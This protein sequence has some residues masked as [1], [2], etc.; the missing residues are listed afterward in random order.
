MVTA[1]SG[2]EPAAPLARRAVV[3]TRARE[4]ASSLVS[5]LAALGAHVVEVPV[6]AI[7]PAADGGAALRQALEDVEAYEWVVVTSVNGVAAVIDVA[8]GADPLRCIHVAAVGSATAAALRAH[9]VEPALVPDRFVAEGLLEVF[10]LPAGSGRVLLAQAEAARPVLAEG[11]RDHGWQVDAVTAYRTVPAEVG[12]VARAAIASADAVTFTSASTVENLVAAVGSAA[13]PSV[14][15]SIG[16][17]TSAAAARAGVTV[18]VEADPHTVDG[19][20]RALVDHFG[21]AGG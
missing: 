1:S 21:K 19:V 9:G 4:Q 17:V 8:G 2:A 18:T 14:V 10:P 11:L 6:I 7:R 16:P 13:L 5:S 20:V 15:V 12:A 3:V